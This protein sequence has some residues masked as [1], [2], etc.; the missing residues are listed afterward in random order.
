MLQF[1]YFF[2]AKI[3]TIHHTS[4]SLEN[5]WAEAATG[6]MILPSMRKGY[7][8]KDLRANHGDPLILNRDAVFLLVEFFYTSKNL[9]RL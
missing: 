7:K 4:P 8:K 9:Y 6:F 1:F 5:N 2:F 3:A